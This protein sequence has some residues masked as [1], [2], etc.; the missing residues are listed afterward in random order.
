MSGAEKAIRVLAAD[1]HALLRQGIASLVTRP[2][3]R[4]S[5]DSASGI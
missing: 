2:S 3:H 5:D 4:I 1:D